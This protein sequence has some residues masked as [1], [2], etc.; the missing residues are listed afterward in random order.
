MGFLDIIKYISSKFN[1]G[2]PEWP[3]DVKMRYLVEDTTDPHWFVWAD[4]HEDV[5]PIVKVDDI[6]ALSE[7]AAKNG[8]RI[9]VAIKGIYLYE[10]KNDR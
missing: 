8:Y 4:V 1:S 10:A 5:A 2:D 9:E 7:V 3:D 6:K